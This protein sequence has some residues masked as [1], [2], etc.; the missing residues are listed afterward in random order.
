MDTRSYVMCYI[1]H[2]DTYSFIAMNGT[3]QTNDTQL[4]KVG[5]LTTES[6][7]YLIYRVTYSKHKCIEF[8]HSVNQIDFNGPELFVIDRPDQ[9]PYIIVWKTKLTN[10][11][12]I[13]VNGSH[14]HVLFDDETSDIFNVIKSFMYQLTKKEFTLHFDNPTNPLNT[15]H[16]P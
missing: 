5:D 2:L 12:E 16:C 6:E 13:C 8:I 3:E 9:T 11:L 14:D 15:H 1:E 10:G 7:T 4:V